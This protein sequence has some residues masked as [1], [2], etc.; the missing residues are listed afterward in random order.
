MNIHTIKKLSIASLIAI[1]SCFTS[2]TRYLD[3]MPD[4]VATLENAFAMRGEA[5]KY[6]FTCYS[7][8]PRD[9]DINGSPALFGGDEIWELPD[10][11]ETSM[12]RQLAEGNQNINSP[13][14]GNYWNRLYSGI[15]D[16][17]IFLE[18][19]NTVPDIE[20]EE[21]LQWIAEVKVLKAYYH[22]MLV[23]MYGPIPLIRTNKPISAGVD[24][25]K[26]ARAPVDE[27]FA[28]IAEILDEAKDDLLLT[29][30]D[31]QYMGKITKAVAYSL[32]A[33]VL[34]FA[35]S[36]LFNGNTDQSS[37]AN[38]DGTTLFNAEYSVAKWQLAADACRE[39][40][41]MCDSAGISLFEHP[42]IKAAYL[43]SD[44]TQNEL[45]L[46]M[47]FSEKWNT[48][49]IWANTQSW[50]NRVQVLASPDW[51][52]SPQARVWMD[53]RYN[54]PLKIVEQFYSNNGVPITEDKTWA[55]GD[56]YTT[57][58]ATH[59]DNHRL[60]IKDGFTTAVL[61]FNR[62]PRFYAYL[63]FDGGIWYG[64][65]RFDDNQP[66]GLFYLQTKLGDP[67][68]T[69]SSFQG[70]IT[71]YSIKKWIHPD[72]V[73]SPSN[74]TTVDYPWPLMRLADLYLLYSECLNEVN[75]PNEEVYLYLDKVR[76]RAGLKGVLE[77]WT[78]YSVNPAKATNQNGLR[79]IIRRERLNELAFEQQ[80]FWDLRRWKMAMTEM[81]KS[82]VGWNVH[83]STTDSYYRPT[84]I[85]QQRFNSKDY[86]WPIA[87]YERNVN[88]NLVQNIGW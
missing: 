16:C 38:L 9:A 53:N 59:A 5:E 69:Q 20:N 2:C 41:A 19:I 23:R 17:N 31:P 22:F 74:Y 4:N 21:R 10:I 27:C 62:E 75:G 40:I 78:E 49:I 14:G 26:V 61:N 68:G 28:Y 35:A 73:R 82:V 64:Q 13:I 8:M 1:A 58:T 77:A 42:A 46:R 3:I 66:S 79:D 70:P 12:Y 24:E 33:K 30:V 83:G 36:P 29:I 80:R 63:G 72:N 65:G 86:F 71:G 34:T 39:A 52:P 84:N 56:R 60:Y 7:Y 67:I 85:F 25:V 51:A 43:I 57:K 54:A 6:L 11:G 15:R 18:N 81:N 48:E 45:S 37:L 55:Y 88:T 50:I 47:S 32:K 44:T 87:E 76:A